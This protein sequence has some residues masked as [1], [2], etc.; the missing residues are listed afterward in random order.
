MRKVLCVKQGPK[1]DEEEE[2]EEEEEEGE[3]HAKLPLADGLV[4]RRHSVG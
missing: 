3:A 1:L 4:T 2:E